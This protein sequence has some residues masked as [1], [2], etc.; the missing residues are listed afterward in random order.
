MGSMGIAPPASEPIA[1]I[2]LS[3]KF[4][5]DASNPEALW[6]LLA[7]KRSAWSEIPSSR[8]N[9]KGAY[10]PNPEKLGTTNV[11]GGHFIEDDIALF[12]APF[13]NLSAEYAAAFDPQFRLQLESAYEALENAGLLL[14]S[15]AGSKTSVY[16]GLWKQDY[17]DNLM[18]DEDNLPRYCATGTGSSFAANRI[19]HFFDLRGASMTIDTACSTSLVA[20]H[21]AVQSLRNRESDMAIVGGSNL[22]LNPDTFKTM[23]SAGFLSA[24]GKSYAFDSRANGYGR[25]EGVATIIVKRLVDAHAAGDPVRAVVRETA[26]NQ[27]GKTESITTPSQAAQVELMRECY[28]RAELDPQDTQY[29]EAHGTGTFVGDPIEAGAVAAVFQKGRSAEQALR[30]GSIKTNIGHTEV[31][32]GLA[33]IIKVILAMEKSIIPPSINFKKSNEKIP[34]DKWRLKLVRDVEEWPVG[35]WGVRRASINNFG[36]GGTN[37]HV[38]MEDGDS[39]GRGRTEPPP[40]PVNESRWGML[41][42]SAK[43]KKACENMVSNLMKYLERHESTK[44]VEELLEAMIYTLGQHRSVFSWIATHPISLT[45]GLDDAKNALGS[46]QFKSVRTSRPP[47]IGFVF[48]GQGA[49]WHAMGRELI[50]G[51][52]TFRESL[53]DADLCLCR[54]GAEWSLLEEL[55]RDAEHSRVNDASISIPICV[56][57][58]IALV[59]LLR[60]WGI[61]PTA[62]TSHS[63]GEIAAAYAVGALNMESAMAV[64]YHRTVLTANENLHRTIKGGMV[65]VGVGVEQTE[66]YLARL[67]GGNRARAACINSPSS[68]TVAGDVS[69][70]QE[71]ED[72]MKADGIF[73]RRLRVDTGYHSHHMESVA[74]P[75]RKAL[76]NSQLEGETIREQTSINSSSPVTGGRIFDAE[77]LSQPAHWVDSMVKPVLFVDAFQDMILGDFDPSGSSVDVIVE[78]GPHTALGSGIKEIMALPAFNALQLP[79]YGCLVRNTDARYSMQHLAAKLLRE[80]QPLDMAAINFPQKIPPQIGVLTDLPSYPWVHQTRYWQESRFNR[81]I[82]NR[83]QPQHEFLGSVASWANPA[84]PSWRHIVR[85]DDSSW[86]RDHV[87]ES[88]IVYPGAG[89][90][91]LAIEAIAQMATIQGNDR[92]ITGFCLRDI[93]I[94]MAFVVPDNADG[95]EIQTILSSVGDKAVGSKDWKKFEIV[96]TTAEG[97]WT[98]HAQGLIV[99]EFD[100]VD[101]TTV[102]NANNKP[103]GYTRC[104]DPEDF[105]TN[106]RRIGL[107]QGPKFQ[108]IKSIVQSSQTKYSM[109]TFVIA[110]TNVAETSSSHLI[111]PTT[112]TSIVQAAYT[113]LPRAGSQLE[114]AMMPTS[115]Q[116]LW[117]SNQISHEPGHL[118]RASTSLDRADRQSVRANVSVINGNEMGTASSVVKI[119]GLILQSFGGGV[120]PGSHDKPWEEDVCSKLEWALDMS[121]ANPANIRSIKHELARNLDP[122]ET[123]TI[124]DLRRTCIYFMH[125][126]LTALCPSEVQQLHKHNK[127]YYSWLQAQVNLA[128]AGQLGLGCTQWAYDNASERQDRIQAAKSSSVNGEMVCQLGPH[129]APILCG[130]QPPL[131]L[132]MENRLLYKYYKNMLKIDRSFEHTAALLKQLVHKNPRARI[133]EIGA[134]TGGGTRYMLPT[135]GT[136]ATGG[137]LAS[138]YHFTDVSAAFFA[139]A[140]EEFSEWADLLQF[141]KLDIETDPAS[142]GFE[143]GGYDIV[144]ACQVLHATQS[145]AN[146]MVNVRKLMKPGGTLLLVETTKDQVDVQF[147]FGLLPGWWLSEEKERHSSPSLSI[148]FWHQILQ[149]AGFTGVDLELHDCESEDMYSMSTIMSTSLPTQPPRLPPG[150]DVVIVTS[151]RNPPQQ[152]WLDSLLDSYRGRVPGKSLPTL[153]NL[154]TAST[155]V[156]AGKI[157]ICIAEAAAQPLLHNLDPVEWEGIK[158][159]AT[160]CKGLLWITRGG[161]DT[162]EKPESGLAAGFLRTLRNEYVGRRFLALDLDPTTPV[163]SDL[164]IPAIV[165]VLETCFGDLNSSIVDDP[166][167]KEFEYMERNG[168]LLVPRFFKDIDRNKAIFPDQIDYSAPENISIEPFQQSA[169]PISLQVGV[170]GMLDTLVFADDERPCC[171]SDALAA[172]I[173][174]IDPRAF[175][176][177]SRDVMVAMGQVEERLMG[178][179][180]AGTITK[181]GVRAASQGFVIGD[182]VMCLLSGP[183]SNR[184]YVEWT[185]VVAIPA[186]LSFEEAASIPLAFTTAYYSLN[187]VARLKR[188]QSVLIHAAAGGVG[189]AAIVLAQYVG[190]TVF[191]T[192]GSPEK[193]SLLTDNYGVVAEHIFSSRD[194][195]FAQGVLAATDGRGVDVILNSLAGSLMQASF[196][197]LAPFGH[198]I[199]IGKSDV[200]RN[201]SLEMRTF[202]RHASFSSVDML[203]M[204]RL[205]GDDVSCMLAEVARLAVNKV[206]RPIK[207]LTVYPISEVT[208]AFQLLQA[209]KHSGKVVLSISPEESVALLPQRPNVRLS[210]NA[211]YLLVGDIVQS[212][213]I[214]MIEHGAKNLIL[215]SDSAVE[216]D[217]MTGFAEQ[218]QQAGCRV[219]ATGCDVSSSLE[220]QRTFGVFQHEGFPPIRGIVHG[221]IIHNVR[222]S[223]NKAPTTVSCFR[224]DLFFEQ[225]SI[226]EQMSLREYNS[227][228]LPNIS[229]TWNLHCQFPHTDEIDFFILLSSNTGILGN[230]GQASHTVVHT[231]QDALARWRVAR[232]LPCVSIDLT[233]VKSVGTQKGMAEAAGMKARMAKLGHSWLDEYVMGDVLESAILQPHPQIIVGINGGPGVHWDGDS[234]SQLGRD[235][236]FTALQHGQQK[237]QQNGNRNRADD[238]SLIIQLAEAGTRAEAEVLVG[239]AIAQKLTDI[240]AIPMEDVDMTKA[241]T[242]YGVDSLVAV[243]LRNMLIHQVGSEVASFDIL[244]GVSLGKLAIEATA[245]SRHVNSELQSSSS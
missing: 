159:M 211:S 71:I 202:A 83:S 208:K 178:L 245:K 174:E 161:L 104:F 173:I 62:V 149:G 166:S 101:T 67:T 96:S 6:Q 29:F 180:C 201:S 192:V 109:A 10:H 16:A 76:C 7:E 185:K 82:R 45:S 217:S 95:I 28:Q 46:P 118:L 120:S 131:E 23:A 181:V 235:A 117:V 34:L 64:A 97:K 53:E 168:S 232:G 155:E 79:Y 66:T 172:D 92:L 153:H 124:M 17:K 26:V 199:E 84:S 89:F 55:Q 200:E 36:Y 85:A 219:K 150:E 91:C 212:I 75:Y 243:E 44:G 105:Y 146:T 210:A 69:A 183:F 238:D 38:V 37:A 197:L 189:Q 209:G 98:Q 241:P 169:R 48:T 25:G 220:L 123:H 207:P 239:E 145:M 142:Q 57:L 228:I 68:V 214:W 59:Q 151:N 73:A 111:H 175:G 193:R 32:S 110:D 18:R 88:S 103:S 143:I 100:S 80:G 128:A 99:T 233:M 135:L 129:L 221:G 4:A 216:V 186:D 134:G 20:L 190:A 244:Q 35:P 147:V 179:E 227:A 31:T 141:D 90:V 125:D 234:P 205:R 206:V 154:E 218:I 8:F 43:T 86:L 78:V 176:V 187:E 106:L 50:S 164:C 225:E 1:I 194:T 81:A 223:E 240:F 58:Q 177:N 204:L 54:L 19:S 60:A 162:C 12:D 138:L 144:I 14:A 152:G 116:K 165:Q 87:I 30:I 222:L 156:Y 39:W 198:F 213:A 139:A 224:A 121:L 115:I 2:G 113:A 114:N 236:R 182:P 21:Q 170:P 72:M 242:E 61:V 160:A 112:L 47:R 188:G 5:G 52:P 70:V 51:Y 171:H 215:L 108:N 230:A 140:S 195:S 158:A 191:T 77:E 167:P 40:R 102:A 42:L 226:L 9:A 11:L 231:Y 229:G 157:C 126:A 132:M 237:Q 184:V 203:A 107:K 3:C 119:E 63:S 122:E 49:Q 41:V 94:Q 93:E 130:K 163:W 15:V 133:L 24:D 27:D 127:K 22:M 56:A 65:A 136:T 196:N 148:P 13:F 33:G 137:P 74:E